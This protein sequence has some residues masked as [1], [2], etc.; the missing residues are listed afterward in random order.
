[1][2]MTPLTQ[3]VGK[4]YP[5]QLYSALGSYDTVSSEK[6]K[7]ETEKTALMGVMSSCYTNTLSEIQTAATSLNGYQT[8]YSNYGYY[9]S[10]WGM[11]Y[12]ETKPYD[13]GYTNNRSLNYWVIDTVTPVDVSGLATS[14][15]SAFICDGDKTSY[16]PVSATMLWLDTSAGEWARAIIVE[17]EVISG[18]TSGSEDDMTY[19][20]VSAEALGYTIP[21]GITD[22][23]DI[24]STYNYS[25]SY[26]TTNY[27]NI[28]IW[29]NKFL[30]VLD[31]LTLP[32][33]S[34]G[35]YGINAKIGSL[36]QAQIITYYNETKLR[37]VDAVYREFTTWKD[38]II[39]D[40]TDGTKPD[41]AFYDDGSD[42]THATSVS[43][44][45]LGNLT[46]VFVSDTD[47]LIDCGSVDREKPGIVDTSTYTD[48][49]YSEYT[50][51]VMVINP[52]GYIYSPSLSAEPL[53][54]IDFLFE[55][56][57]ETL[58]ISGGSAIPSA[59]YIDPV[60]FAVPGNQT[61]I[62]VNGINIVGEYSMSNPRYFKVQSSSVISNP[63]AGR[64]L[65]RL[66]E[67]LPISTGIW[68]V[69]K[70]E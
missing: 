33:G 70:Y 22:I 62:F 31:H 35:T 47:I 59:T 2:S 14:G 4:D 11:Y 42:E 7:A 3:L 57:F 28:A 43:F 18:A 23:C 15:A 55:D 44:S 16:F 69:S 6:T 10:S 63:L 36:S 65:I 38:H 39:L 61:N 37:G 66:K 68:R 25:S 20:S 32:Y 45:C 52:L 12:D 67:S 60:T 49:W 8:I 51:V 41:V 13:D 54:A 30:F 19:V 5:V 56:D 50:E 34:T 21:T 40:N 48:S 46:S 58:S 29:N 64:T 27:P 26:I 1:M 9:D 53:S 17:S 24:I